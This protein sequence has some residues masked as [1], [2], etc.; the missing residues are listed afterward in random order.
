MPVSLP[1][2]TPSVFVGAW[3]L[4]PEPASLQTPLMQSPPTLQALSASHLAQSPPQSISVSFP[5]FEPSLQF[6]GTQ[7]FVARLQTPDGQSAAFA[8]DFAGVTTALSPVELS[9]PG[10]TMPP[11][12]PLP[13]SLLS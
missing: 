8:Q 6:A 11:S 4:S 3:H 9:L 10:V 1:F 2:C 5:F 7:S 13:P 12:S